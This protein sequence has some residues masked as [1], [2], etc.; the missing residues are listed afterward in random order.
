MLFI[1]YNA[2]FLLKNFLNLLL[3]STIPVF[4]KISLLFF[5]SFHLLIIFPMSWLVLKWILHFLFLLPREKQLIIK[6]YFLYPK[7]PPH[8]LLTTKSMIPRFTTCKTYSLLYPN[9]SRFNPLSQLMGSKPGMKIIMSNSWNSHL[10]FETS[11]ISY[12]FINDFVAVEIDWKLNLIH[13]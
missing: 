10:N 6:Q 8:A 11:L 9:P 1:I 5:F 2:S 4:F 3:F 12:I 13:T 7:P